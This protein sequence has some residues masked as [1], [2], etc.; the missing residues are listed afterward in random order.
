ML[1]GRKLILCLHLIGILLVFSGCSNGEDE[2]K[3]LFLKGKEVVDLLVTENYEELHELFFSEELKTSLPL[4]ELRDEWRMMVAD[5]GEYEELFA[6]KTF[7]RGDFHVYEQGVGYT[8]VTI[9]VR[10]IL[11]N[12]KELVSLHFDYGSA[13]LPFPEGIVEETVI[14]GEGGDYELNGTLTLPEYGEEG[15]MP[16]V[17]LVHGSG[18]H[19]QDSAVFG[20]KPFRDIAWGLAERGIAVLRYDKRTY[21]YGNSFTEEELRA[22]SVQEETVEDAILAGE[23]LKKDGR[24][25][26]DQVYLLGHSLGGM[27]APRIDATGGDFAGLLIMAGSPRALWEIIYDQNLLVLNSEEIS[28][29]EREELERMLE[30]ERDKAQ[31]L[32]EMNEEEALGETL[33]TLPAYYF[34]EMELVDRIALVKE[35]KKP[36]LVLQGEADFQVSYDRDYLR[37]KE[38]LG[39][40]ATFNSYPGLNHFFVDYDGANKG[41]LLEYEVPGI[42][43]EEVIADMADWI[44]VQYKNER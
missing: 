29:A 4:M 28:P 44:M 41:T 23:L 15:S 5:A 32:T 39:E 30:T 20:Y 19:D 24:I 21:V 33:F 34:K 35:F 22:F 3:S 37:W 6:A 14:I 43:A 1:I 8:Y 7:E 9:Q 10:L 18:P 11:N 25:D 40:N 16:A 38:L 12:D 31:R 2:E 36:V 13:N 42:V 27:L 26:G 17:V